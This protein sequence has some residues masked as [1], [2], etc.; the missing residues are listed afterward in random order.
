MGMN[1][2]TSRKKVVLPV[3]ISFAALLTMLLTS[4]LVRSA[5]NLQ[6]K[7]TLISEPCVVTADSQELSVNFGSVVDKFLYANGQSP[8]QTFTFHLAECNTDVA[9][10]AAITLQGTESSV[11]PGYLKLDA[12]S[13]ATGV[14]I[15]IEQTDGERVAINKAAEKFRI[16]SG[17]NQLTLKAY[18]KG[19]PDAIAKN[20]IQAGEFSA[21]ATFSFAY[22]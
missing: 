15:G 18:V 4:S 3:G 11:L 8:A 14:A 7:G 10:N 2:M 19:E 22:E 6:F 13:T 5:D 9:S 17:D 21:T 20:T 1:S 16:S 12:S